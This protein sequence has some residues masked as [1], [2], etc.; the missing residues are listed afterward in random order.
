MDDGALMRAGG[1]VVNN[2]EDKVM[3]GGDEGVKAARKT[4]DYA[5]LVEKIAVEREQ[6]D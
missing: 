1:V 5:S 6:G 4:D 2:A 3:L